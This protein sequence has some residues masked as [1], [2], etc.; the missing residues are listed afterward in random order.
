[1]NHQTLIIVI[2]VSHKMKC[3]TVYDIINKVFLNKIIKFFDPKKRSTRTGLYS[4]YQLWC[5][6]VSINVK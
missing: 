3:I 1:M 2:A 5:I 6:F 4:I